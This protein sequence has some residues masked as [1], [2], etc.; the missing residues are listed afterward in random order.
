MSVVTDANADGCS[1]VQEAATSY[2]GFGR[3]DHFRFRCYWS[4]DML[5]TVSGLA[6][7]PQFQHLWGR[8]VY[9]FRPWRHCIRCLKSNRAPGVVPT[10][11]D[12]S[13]ELADR[14]FYLCGVGKKMSELLY[15]ECARRL[16]NVHLAV[17]PRKGSTAT[18]HSSSGVIFVID[19]AEAIPIETL[20]DPFQ[21]LPENHSRCKNF[22]FGYQMFNVDEVSDSPGEIVYELRERWSGTPLI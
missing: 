10:M 20:P 3:S 11:R 14:L 2:V 9:G 21:G 5:L 8:Y 4:Y 16:T 17:R 18:V 22:Q 13:V 7:A 6:A 12:G 19:D 15:P 1:A